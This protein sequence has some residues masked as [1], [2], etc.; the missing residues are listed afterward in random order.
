MSTKLL[1]IASSSKAPPKYDLNSA[2]AF[3]ENK[4]YNNHL[5]NHMQILIII[6]HQ[7]CTSNKDIKAFVSDRLQRMDRIQN[8]S[9]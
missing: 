5:Y 7:E 8:E 6:K 3:K 4:T 1:R 9:S 2:T